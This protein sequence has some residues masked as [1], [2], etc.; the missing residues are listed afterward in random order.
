MCPKYRR[1][2]RPLALSTTGKGGG[3]PA[4]P[5]CDGLAPAGPKCGRGRRPHAL[6]HGARWG[7]VRPRDLSAG[8]MFACPKC[9]RG[10][11]RLR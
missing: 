3:A 11:A 9:H 1:V 8:G 6:C 10:G 5:K 4:Y 2:V 7:E